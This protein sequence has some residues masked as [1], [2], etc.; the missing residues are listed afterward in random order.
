MEGVTDLMEYFTAKE[1]CELR[2]SSHEL[3]QQPLA[4]GCLPPAIRFLENR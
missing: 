1:S 4:A 3:S 2:A